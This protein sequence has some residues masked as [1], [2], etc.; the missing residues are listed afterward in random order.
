MKQLFI[1][2]IIGLSLSYYGQS[3][4]KRNTAQNGNN[5]ILIEK[6]AIVL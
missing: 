3:L 1:V 5:G 2:L 4:E 6:S